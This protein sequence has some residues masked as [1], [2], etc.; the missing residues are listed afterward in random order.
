[1]PYSETT[2]VSALPIPMIEP[3][4]R[5][6][7]MTLTG[8]ALLHGARL[9]ATSGTAITLPAITRATQKEAR[10]AARCATKAL[11]ERLRR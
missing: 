4:G 3:S 8:A 11:A 10:A 1:M 7:L 9:S 2:A 6:A 5:T